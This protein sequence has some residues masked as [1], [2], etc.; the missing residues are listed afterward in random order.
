METSTAADK[1]AQGTLPGPALV[2]PAGVAGLAP[3]G[4]TKGCKCP[5]CE[6]KRTEWRAR[7]AKRRGKPLAMVQPGAAARPALSVVPSVAGDVLPP[8]APKP[9]VPWTLDLVRPLIAQAANLIEK[10]D[11]ETLVAEARKVSE[12]VAKFCESRCAWNA[13]AKLMLVDGA[14]E[15]A[16]KYLNL[17]GVSAEY[18]PEIK[19]GLAALSIVNARQ[20]LLT[21]LRKMADE[22]KPKD[23]ERKAA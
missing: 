7:D 2:S 17:S 15:C 19:F 9:F 23:G 21:E 11:G 4:V 5:A 1:A 13:E 6:A 16:V 3:H 12:A 18:L 14:A 10:W 8:V 20:T 22:A